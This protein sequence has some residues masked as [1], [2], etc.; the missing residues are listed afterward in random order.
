MMKKEWIMDEWY[1]SATHNF[2]A[3]D[4][5]RHSIYQIRC[6][7]WS[8][9]HHVTVTFG[10]PQIRCTKH[11][12]P[13]WI[14]FQ[15]LRATRTLSIHWTLAK[16]KTLSHSLDSVRLFTALSLIVVTSRV[17]LPGHYTLENLF[18]IYVDKNPWAVT[19]AWTAMKLGN[20]IEAEIICCMINWWT[21][22]QRS[23]VSNHVK[24]SQVIP[25]FSGLLEHMITSL[26]SPPPPDLP[27]S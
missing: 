24:L 11:Q 10:I 8:Q 26:S 25:V 13:W 4:H 18:R 2:K 14:H 3:F 9:V 20:A 12:G 16:C 1:C 7:T 21:I 5:W 22:S 17:N 15:V 23:C 27:A 6:V 19:I